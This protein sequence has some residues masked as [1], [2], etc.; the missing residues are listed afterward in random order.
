[1]PHATI[2]AWADTLETVLGDA[3]LGNAVL[4]DAVLGDADA[5]SRMDGLVQQLSTS[6]AS[7]NAARDVEKRSAD[8]ELERLV[9]IA[10]ERSV[11]IEELMVPWAS[12]F[13]S[14]RPA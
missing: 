3:M 8:S 6:M 14:Y 1:M 9:T 12:A 4:S 13:F 11:Q 10:S 2:R 5:Y 7:V